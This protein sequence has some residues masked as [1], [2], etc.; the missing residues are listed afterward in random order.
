MG[1]KSKYI[2]DGWN[3]KLDL[4]EKWA[5]NGL[6][7]KEIAD[8]M[9]INPD[10]LYTYQNKFPMF[11][12]AIKNGKSKQKKIV[13][14]LIEKSLYKSEIKKQNLFF[15]NSK[16]ENEMWVNKNKK[17]V[18]DI[19]LRLKSESN[20][21]FEGQEED[22]EAYYYNNMTEICKEI[23]L[24]KVKKVIKQKSI[25]L[26][27][28]YIRPDLLTIHENGEKS[29]FEVKCSNSKNNN[30]SATEQCKGLGQ[31]MLYSSYIKE[32]SGERPNLFLISDKI[33][34]RTVMAFSDFGLPVTLMEVQKNII[35]IPY[36][37]RGR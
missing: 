29:V 36:N 15:Y 5:E 1:R 11:F 18:K 27:N 6:T 32:M 31:L 33:Y 26:R 10:T 23:G 4:I 7:N 3:E 19:S 34:E 30:T 12:K 2:R 14:N 8:N 20:F 25:K 35:F 28:K 13:N 9:G 22:L 21:I 17:I 16:K 37:K 24:P